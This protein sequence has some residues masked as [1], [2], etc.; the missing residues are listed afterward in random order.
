MQSSRLQSSTSFLLGPFISIISLE[1][2]HSVIFITQLSFSLD[3]A[4]NLLTV[5]FTSDNCSFLSRI[6]HVNVEVL[7][8]L[9]HCKSAVQTHQHTNT[10]YIPLHVEYSFKSIYFEVHDFIVYKNVFVYIYAI[11]PIPV[12]LNVDRGDQGGV[13]QGRRGKVVAMVQSC[14]FQSQSSDVDTMDTEM[15]Y[16]YRYR[17]NISSMHFL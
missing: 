16:V 17:H 2:C 1:T 7:F 3:S 15:T 14:L 9:R 11:I 12:L 5:D 6:S 8:V 10:Q 4:N 13:R